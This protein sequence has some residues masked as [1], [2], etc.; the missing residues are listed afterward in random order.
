[1]CG[2]RCLMNVKV[3]LIDGEA[4]DMVW[5]RQWNSRTWWCRRCFRLFRAGGCS[6]FGHWRPG[7][8]VVVASG[9][10]DCWI[11]F[12]FFF[13]PCNWH[14][15]SLTQLRQSMIQAMLLGY[16]LIKAY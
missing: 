9:G 15:I 4:A 1:M 8:L 14:R 13:P 2:R 10:Y 5:S 11:V 7:S 6:F 3:G 12:F 16:I